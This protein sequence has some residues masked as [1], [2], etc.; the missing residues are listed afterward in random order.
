MAGLTDR[1]LEIKRLNEIIEESQ[2]RARE[3]FQDLVPPDENVD[4]SDSSALGRLIGLK[5]PAIADLWELAQQ[6]YLAFDP[7]SAAGI[8]L[9]NLVALSGISRREQSPT[10]AD[11]YVTGVPGTIITDDTMFGTTVNNTLYAPSREFMLSSEAAHQIGVNVLTASPGTNYSIF[12]RISQDSPYIEVDYQSGSSA[13]PSTI[14]NGLKDAVTE[15]HSGIRAIIEDDTLYILGA[16]DYRVFDF[17]TSGNLGITSVTNIVRVFAEDAGPIQQAPGTITSIRTPVLGLDAVTNPSSAIVGTFRETDSQLRNRFRDSKFQM[18][19]NIIESLYSELIN[20]AGVIGAVIYENDT[21]V[22]NETYNLPPHSFKVIVDGGLELDVAKAIWVNRPAGILSVGDVSIDI[23]D[24]FGYT[25]N[26]RFSR[27][28]PVP[29]KIR[30]SLT[31]FPDFPEDGREK[32][33]QAIRNSLGNQAIGQAVIYS[34]L[35]TP[36]NSVPGHQVDNL[37]L[38]LD[39]VEW[40]KDN[41]EIGIGAKADIANVEIIFE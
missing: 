24:R 39:G 27:P 26:I 22:H 6:V 13:T 34:R 10:T 4:T 17:Y 11:L 23:I 38:S 12:Y 29:F 1:G 14:L 36:I 7:N 37:E 30:I 16:I 32:I 9:D 21:N 25:R 20:T 18:A 35:Y 19:S 41:I 31:T 3:L 8:Q 2:E 5:S 15:D 40:F 33:A 28:E